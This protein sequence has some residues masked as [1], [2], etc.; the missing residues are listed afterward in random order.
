MSH[1]WNQ[2][3]AFQDV[4]YTVRFTCKMFGPKTII[5]VLQGWFYA[6][7]AFASE[8]PYLCKGISFKVMQDDFKVISVDLKRQ[9]EELNY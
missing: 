4:I 9:I 8:S 5:I 7:D 3:D 6:S 1:V 2:E